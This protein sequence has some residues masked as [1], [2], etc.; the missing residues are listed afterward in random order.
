MIKF[1]NV[2]LFTFFVSSFSSAI[3][4]NENVNNIFFKVV[5]KDKIT[6]VDGEE[7]CLSKFEVTN[8]S[9]YTIHF[10]EII[11]FHIRPKKYKWGSEMSNLVNPDLKKKEVDIDDEYI[12][13][14]TIGMTANIQGYETAMNYGENSSVINYKKCKRIKTY[15]IEFS[16]ESVNAEAVLDSNE[17]SIQWESNKEAYRK[18]LK[19]LSPHPEHD[20]GSFG[21]IEFDRLSGC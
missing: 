19:L 7:A 6:D 14:F 21:K 15:V 12:D 13:Y 18:V 10:Q 1:I 3:F 8:N 17:D 2:I 11:P 5:S 20:E 16:C 9:I 4:A